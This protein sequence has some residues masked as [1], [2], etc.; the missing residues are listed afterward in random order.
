[1]R[2]RKNKANSKPNKANMTTFSRKSEYL[3]PK[4]ETTASNRAHLKKQSQFV[5]R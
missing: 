1:L 3:S 2:R 4:S 5:K